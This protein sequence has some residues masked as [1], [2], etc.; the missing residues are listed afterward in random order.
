M[1]AMA[2]GRPQLDF[3]DEN[4]EDY[5]DEGE[6]FYQEYEE[7]GEDYGYY[8]Y[9]DELEDAGES[10]SGIRKTDLMR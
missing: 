8:N 4:Q 3:G 2:S 10:I 9:N 6:Y 7:N 1:S 5:Y